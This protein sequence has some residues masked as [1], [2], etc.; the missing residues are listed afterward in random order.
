MGFGF[1][2]GVSAKS[3]KS[4]RRNERL[5]D[6]SRPM[7]NLGRQEQ[8]A[9][10]RQRRADAKRRRANE[11]FLRSLVRSEREAR[12]ADR[13]M[14]RLERQSEREVARRL[15]LIGNEGA[16]LI[17]S[18][19]IMARAV[20]QLF[21]SIAADREG[22]R[23]RAEISRTSQLKNAKGETSF[24]F[25]LT[26][27]SKDIDGS[28]SAAAH[29]AYVRRE[30]AVGQVD[31]QESRVS[32]EASRIVGYQARD[33]AVG[34]AEIPPGTNPNEPAPR[35]QGKMMFG[36]ISP[37]MDEVEEIWRKIAQI[38]RTP[39]PDKLTPAEPVTDPALLEPAVD[40][41]TRLTE[42]PCVIDWDDDAES[43]VLLT[44]Q[45]VPSKTRAALIAAVQQTTGVKTRFVAGRGGR[46]QYRLIAGL[47]HELSPAGMMTV[48]DRFAAE[49]FGRFELPYFGAVHRPDTGNNPL[50]WHVHLAF[51]DRPAKIIVLEDGTRVWDFE[52]TRYDPIAKRNVAYLRREKER[53]LS[54]KS[55]VK[56]LREL[57]A[58]IVNDQLAAEGHAKR[59]HAGTFEDMGIKATPLTRIDQKAYAMEMRGVETKAG[60]QKAHQEIA[61]RSNVGQRATPLQRAVTN[62]MKDEATRLLIRR[63]ALIREISQREALL[64][65][66]TV[67]SRDKLENR[68]RNDREQL[69]IVNAM[70][71]EVHG[72]ANDAG[73]ATRGAMKGDVIQRHFAPKD[74]LA[75]G[76]KTRSVRIGDIKAPSPPGLGKPDHV[77]GIVIAYDPQ[78]RRVAVIAAQEELDRIKPDLIGTADAIARTTSAFANMQRRSPLLA[79]K[80]GQSAE[81][82]PLRRLIKGGSHITVPT[83]VDNQSQIPPQIREQREIALAQ[84]FTGR[85]AAELK[86]RDAREAAVKA[87][88]DKLWAKQQLIQASGSAVKTTT[89]VAE[90]A[91][92]PETPS[93]GVIDGLTFQ[94]DKPE[95]IIIPPVDTTVLEP[96]PV[97]TPVAAAPRTP[98]VNRA[99]VMQTADAMTTQI[100][101][102]W[103]KGLLT[104]VDDPDQ[105]RGFDREFVTDV[106]LDLARAHPEETVQKEARSVLKSEFDPAT[107]TQT[108]RGTIRAAQYAAEVL[109]AV[110]QDDEAKFQRIILAQTIRENARR[111]DTPNG[112]MIEVQKDLAFG[113]ADPVY[114]TTVFG[115]STRFATGVNKYAV[116]RR[117]AERY[118]G[119]PEEVK[120]KNRQA[121]EKTVR[122]SVTEFEERLDALRAVVIDPLSVTTPDPFSTDRER[123]RAFSK[124]PKLKEEDVIR[125]E[126]HSEGLKRFF[127]FIKDDNNTLLNAPPLDVPPLIDAIP[128]SDRMMTIL[129]QELG[130][131]MKARDPF[132][133]APLR[134]R[135]K[136]AAAEQR[137]RLATLDKFRKD[138]LGDLS[139]NPSRQQQELSSYLYNEKTSIRPSAFRNPHRPQERVQVR[140]VNPRGPS[141]GERGR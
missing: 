41:V 92:T 13:V 104:Y 75:V 94:I 4:E 28:C 73:K 69:K 123:E 17:S 2:V 39:K 9:V 127:D 24:H 36:N 64:K 112:P 42:K 101:N 3:A 43:Y 97:E 70:L 93:F 27:V 15:R 30:S 136:E 32:A 65:K 120:E 14:R 46:V 20:D 56:R 84:R 45:E 40:A 77:D 22:Y 98:Q 66:N 8:I 134:A 118:S 103:T 102:A 117:D 99:M 57:F 137:P 87:Q 52:A 6:W 82:S 96:Q 115:E 63:R 60:L 131:E 116:V 74:G 125:R 19:P 47:P 81:R 7:K 34:V 108:S 78:Q 29:V 16:Y 133:S 126:F 31:E 111:V 54:E 50:N 5:N 44:G 33:G 71:V 10:A 105:K 138:V 121:A 80:I 130:I 119:D 107:I 62:A 89:S 95:Q 128:G 1:A 79:P 38:E 61:Q 53:W 109:A 114:A 11:Q 51:H 48:C 113:L 90:K 67:R 91:A 132:V 55:A 140:D 49:A 110:N 35:A 68:L 139:K 100:L 21:G 12:E 76:W 18:R 85:S 86:D 83:F 25:K 141:R 135:V 106:F 72:H 122:F 124:D 88:V 26:P 58:S 23:R 129:G 37:D 59:W